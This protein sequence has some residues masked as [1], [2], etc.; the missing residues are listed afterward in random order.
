VIG[1][2]GV[3]KSC[4]MRYFIE[5][6]F[7]KALNHTVGVEFG[8]KVLTLG[9]KQ[10]KLQIW[11]TAGQER[12]RT[13]TRAYYRGAVGC[14][15]VYD[16]TS[17]AS[18]DHLTTWLD[19]V[20]HL[21]VPGI[22]IVLVGNKSDMNKMREVP[23][24]EASHFAMNHGLF[25]L[26]TSAATGEGVDE[27]FLKCTSAIVQKIEAGEIVLDQRA[28]ATSASITDR[29]EKPEPDAGAGCKC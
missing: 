15:L 12:F 7:R 11:D 18:Y 3:G 5:R 22:Q 25:F 1:D 9:S 13:V 17:R 6:K 23:F 14:L 21:A 20:R 29:L 19:D 27:A 24:F 26:E 10:V 8:S 28:A 16:I 4:I 2:A